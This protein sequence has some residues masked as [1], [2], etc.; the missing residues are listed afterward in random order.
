MQHNPSSDY[1]ENIYAKYG[2]GKVTVNGKE[3]VDSWY[4][5]IKDYSFSPGGFT[6]NTGYFEFDITLY[7][8]LSMYN[9]INRAFYPSG[10]ER[11]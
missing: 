4:A 2:T 9:C 10:L 8:S 5:E 7:R 11:Y 1:G 6:M 3:A